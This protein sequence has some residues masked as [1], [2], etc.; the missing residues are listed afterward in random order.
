MDETALVGRRVT[1]LTT[2]D[3]A[4]A[5]EFGFVI[6]DVDLDRVLGPGRKL[7]FCM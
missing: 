7:Q 4:L 5:I 6:L 3:S 2:S 1:D